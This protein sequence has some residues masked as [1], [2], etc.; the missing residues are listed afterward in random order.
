MIPPASVL[1]KWLLLL[2]PALVPV[3]LAEASPQALTAQARPPRAATT[4]TATLPNGVYLYGNAPQ[5]NQLSHSYV[6]FERDNGKVVGAFYSPRSEFTCFAGDLQG[7]QLEVEAL[8]DEDSGTHAVRAQ[9]SQLYP[10]PQVSANDQRM[11]ATCRQA[12]IS[13]ASGRQ[14]SPL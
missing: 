10:I 14:P 7:T 11:L 3:T 4:Q 12:T 6:V 9:L 8:A 1:P 2:I 5:P 13:L